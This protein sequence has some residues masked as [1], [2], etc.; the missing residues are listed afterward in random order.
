MGI[1][2][3]SVRGVSLGFLVAASVAVVALAGATAASTSS[4]ADWAKPIGTLPAQVD[5]STKSARVRKDAPDPSCSLG[6][7]VVWY[8]ATAPRRG[9]MLASVAAGGDS[10]A[11]RDIGA[12]N[13]TMS[14]THTHSNHYF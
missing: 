10:D 13:R 2:G 9:P 3:V 8:T 1:R 11:P 14:D 6:Q 5:G 12:P 4:W 7:G